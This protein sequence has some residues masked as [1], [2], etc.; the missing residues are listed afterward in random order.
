[1]TL[2]ANLVATS[3]RVGA[4]S[5]RLAKI[6][7]L[8]AFLRT[9]AVEEIETGAH[10][11]SGEIQQG[12]IGIGYAALR[13]AAD[14]SAVEVGQLSLAEVDAA[15]TELG[16]D[17][18]NLSPEIL[19]T[20]EHLHS[21]G[22]A[23]TRRQANRIAVTED[24]RVLDVGCGIGGPARYLAHTYGCRVDGIDLT[25]E[26]IETGRVLTERCKLADRVVLQ[27]GNA[28]DLPYPDQT[29][30]VVWCQN[31]A[32]NISDKAGLL[33]GAYRVLKPGGLF[34]STE[35]SVGAG[36]DII[37]PVPWAYDSS[38]NFL[39]PADVMR[40]R[41]QMAGFR[42]LEWVNY[43]NVVIEHYEKMLRS[44]PQLTNRLIFGDD[45]PER[46]RNSQRNLIE[47]RAIYWMITAE[48]PRL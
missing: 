43:S 44:P 47:G 14:S 18:Q 4:T 46:Q 40:A 48:R 34:T 39:E 20:L 27:V 13:A 19:A 3:Q 24:S 28:L 37:F 45:A 23:T 12:R 6:R 38:I 36:G 9:L 1:M 29:F 15:L 16:H 11:L 32:M 2:L 30:D 17:P 41:Y 25:P 22:L 10:Y 8:A 7:E 42:I 33:E 35:Y 5:G 31:V 26:L 21:G